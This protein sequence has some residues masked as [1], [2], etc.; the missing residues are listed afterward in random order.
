MDG[1]AINP[2]TKGQTRTKGQGQGQGYPLPPYGY[3]QFA[4][5]PGLFCEAKKLMKW[6]KIT[7][8]TRFWGFSRFF[9]K[10]EESKSSKFIVS[11]L[12]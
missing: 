3:C 8:F 1:N 4:S 12:F 7:Q 2:G 11:N 5:V 9:S 10:K 6:L